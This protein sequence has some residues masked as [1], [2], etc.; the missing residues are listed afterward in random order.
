MPESRR[1]RLSPVLLALSSLL[2]PLIFAAIL[3]TPPASPRWGRAWALIAA[4]FAATVWSLATL[5]PHDRGLLAERFKPPLQR[6]QPWPD[7][8]VT[9]LLLLGFVAA[10]RFVPEDVFVL[11]LMPAPP[12]LL[13]SLGLALVLLGWWIITGALRANAFAAPVVKLQ[14]ERGQRVIDDGPYAVVRHPMYAGA[15][16]FEIGI[17]LWLG[18]Y[19]G[20]LA[21][22]VPIAILL[23]RIAIEERFLVREL[24]GYAAYTTRVPSRLLP[25]VW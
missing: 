14:K 18:S 5:Y 13:A 17:P 12:P 4:I 9:A 19:A 8:V 20:V 3:L 1:R 21:A 22:G 15:V 7:R 24:R 25:G 16:L 11:H 2:Q 6:G 23:L 10:V